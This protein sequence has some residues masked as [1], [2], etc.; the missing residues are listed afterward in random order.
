MAKGTT[1]ATTDHDFAKETAPLEQFYYT[2]CTRQT[3][4]I[5]NEEY[6]IRA[7]SLAKPEL[8]S[9]LL[10][11][12]PIAQYQLPLGMRSQ[13]LKSDLLGPGDAPVRLARL[14][15][16]D[17]RVAIV[18]AVHRPTDTAGRPLC[19]FAHVLI[20]RPGERSLSA[21]QAIGLWGVEGNWGASDGLVW[22]DHP[23]LVGP[24][25]D[26]PVWQWKSRERPLT[27]AAIRDFLGGVST[28]VASSRRSLELMPRRLAGTQGLPLRRALLES[29]LAAYLCKRR[30]YSVAEPGLAAL[31]ICA[32]TEL[33]PPAI[34]QDLTFS[35]FEPYHS[36]NYRACDAEVI[37]TFWGAQ[38]SSTPES[39]PQDSVALN[40]FASLRTEATFLPE[41]STYAA[42]A[43]DAAARGDFANLENTWK[44]LAEFDVAALTD[45]AALLKIWRLYNRIRQMATAPLTV[46][47]L[48]EYLRHDKWRRLLF[49]SAAGRS[50]AVKFAADHLEEVDAW[51]PKSPNDSLRKDL[52]PSV[53]DFRTLVVDHIAKALVSASPDCQSAD[54][55]YDRLLRPLTD[56]GFRVPSAIKTIL[57]RL[58]RAAPN[59][60]PARLPRP[61]RYWVLR[62]LVK[63]KLG[64]SMA[65][66]RDRWLDVAKPE[67]LED[68][69]QNE[70]VPEDWRRDAVFLYLSHPAP[71]GQSTAAFLLKNP[72][73]FTEVV[74]AAR[75]KDP[76]GGALAKLIPPAFRSSQGSPGQVQFLLWFLQF[77]ES[78]PQRV[79]QKLCSDM[80]AE[81]LRSNA[82]GSLVPWE[83]FFSV[84][85][86]LRERLLDAVTLDLRSAFWA[87][88]VSHVTESCLP[89]SPLL[90]GLVECDQKGNI[91]W[92]TGAENAQLKLSHWKRVAKALQALPP[93]GS[94][95]WYKL[96]LSM[97]SLG[98]L[99]DKGDI[100]RALLRLV[101]LG[102]Q[103][104]GSI[105][106][107]GDC[108]RTMSRDRCDRAA[109]T[110]YV[111][112]ACN[113]V[114]P[115]LYDELVGDLVREIWG[116]DAARTQMEKDL[117]ELYPPAA[118][119]LRPPPKPG[120]PKAGRG[121]LS[122]V[123]AFWTGPWS[124]LAT[125]L[126]GIILST[127]L[128]LVAVAIWVM[129]QRTA[130]TRLEETGKQKQ[131]VSPGSKRTPFAVPK[132]VRKPTPSEAVKTPAP[133]SDANSPPPPQSAPAATPTALP[134]ESPQDV[135]RI[136]PA[137][138][139]PGAMETKAGAPEPKPAAAEP[140]PALPGAKPPA[141]A[142][143]DSR[144]AP[145]LPFEA[146]QATQPP[147]KLGESRKE[148]PHEAPIFDAYPVLAIVESNKVLL[149]EYVESRL[150]IWDP[151]LGAAA[152][153]FENK[154]ILRKIDVGKISVHDGTGK[155]LERPG[156][157][158]K[159]TTSVLLS[160]GMPR[161]DGCSVP[162]WLKL[163]WK[164]L[165]EVRVLFVPY[166]DKQQDIAEWQNDIYLP[167]P[168]YGTIEKR[169][170]KVLVRIK[171][172][173]YTKRRP[174][175]TDRAC[176]INAASDLFDPRT[177]EVVSIMSLKTL[178]SP[179]LI[180]PERRKVND[181]YLANLRDDIYAVVC[182]PRPAAGQ[183]A[184]AAIDKEEAKKQQR[185]ASAGSSGQSP[186]GA[187]GDANASQT[188][189]PP[190]TA[191]APANQAKPK[192]DTLPTKPFQPRSPP[193]KAV[194]DKNEV[195][196]KP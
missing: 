44:S 34:G 120:R 157:A 63:L 130:P 102:P 46:D 174:Q 101:A 76:Q 114:S 109:L 176:P 156:D 82:S 26:L 93:A 53:D 37:N 23:N 79:F 71:I 196:R 144:A 164:N 139:K 110:H 19:H 17:G 177:G 10:A 9:L 188:G 195:S 3:S 62:V 48:Q 33:I 189:K 96:R 147:P 20:P 98:L 86:R 43:V 163:T 22:E 122:R 115:L 149:G 116:D 7:A 50:Q 165:S 65:A 35:T 13:F 36:S 77:E 16:K 32:L 155:L 15:L 166:P 129:T 94:L 28:P 92:T 194:L 113:V 90:D 84:D 141:N 54:R 103:Y 132:D 152:T 106:E 58:E 186:R 133:K 168:K 88:C 182:P 91:T 153:D 81:L 190:P 151:D 38:D 61:T 111:L 138:E 146:G 78:V 72:Q 18:H 167:R 68:L 121:L 51:W 49:G 185:T 191:G 105:A 57:D 1:P 127:I 140:K 55:M 5:G 154:Y 162:D 74:K 150:P 6:S 29:F 56:D 45:R 66:Q 21:R 25:Q 40:T 47:E 39:L 52:Q 97:K 124:L 170:E 70:D 123:A 125:V 41:A 67:D 12:E 2:Y 8:S 187:K 161:K 159:L 173:S 178:P 73:L 11:I 100:L 134:P 135:Q 158:L 69:S 193:G 119:V 75:V 171:D 143:S 175:V 60:V 31:M 87:A 42:Y 172:V 126:A 27:R 104:G 85:T 95:D 160:Y 89:S 181:V 108:A 169:E 14:Q 148:E 99:D 59:G 80:L 24:A 30:I 128:S 118:R 192:Q 112:G 131:T 136:P 83:S 184:A 142:A 179:V 64:E 4:K 183:S 180:L 137:A 117:R 145:S 107:I